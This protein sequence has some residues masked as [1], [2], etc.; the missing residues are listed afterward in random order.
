[1]VPHKVA[2]TSSMLPS[3]SIECS[4][5]HSRSSRDGS[6]EPARKRARSELDPDERKEARAHRNR[7]AAQNSRDK[8]KAHLE[9]LE[10]RVM[11]LEEENRR[12][13][14]GMSHF[15]LG[16]TEDQNF[17]NMQAESS[18]ERENQELRERIK[19]LEKGWSAVV[20]ALQVSGLPLNIS[21]APTI[22]ETISP[23]SSDSE[24]S[25][26]PC[27]PV[28]VPQSPVFPISPALSP[29]S[30]SSSSTF[31]ELEP[32]RHLA[33][34]GLATTQVHEE[35][36]TSISSVNTKTTSVTLTDEV[37]MEDLFREIIAPFPCSSSESLSA[38]ASSSEAQIINDT[39]TSLPMSSMTTSDSM[40]WEKELEMQKLLDVLT[41]IQPEFEDVDLSSAL[42]LELGRWNTA[43][44]VI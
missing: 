18:K 6:C 39:T 23:L 16:K 22:T 21:S 3:P 31:D 12:L 20:Q 38:N 37:A 30:L 24:R 32:T 7:I 13:R 17:V 11:A 8:R 9:C 1:M 25:F 40:D 27:F 28:L 10:A 2:T 33:A 14:A 26:T 41:G 5:I 15:P 42:E 29:L 35:L 4:S 34:G 44:G 19:T 43:I 36:K